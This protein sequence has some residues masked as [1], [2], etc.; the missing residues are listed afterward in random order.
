LSFTFK[1]QDEILFKGGRLWRPR[2]LIS[3]INANDP[4]QLSPTCWH[5]SYLGQPGSSPRK[6]QQ[7]SLMTFLIKSTHTC[8]QPLV[9]DMV[10]PYL[11]RDVFERPPE[12]LQRSPNF[13]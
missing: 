6:P 5:W 10:K 2:F 13:T 8:G 4:N 3:I 7:K 1:S 9:K 11:N 12:L